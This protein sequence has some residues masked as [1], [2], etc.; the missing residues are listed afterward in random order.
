VIDVLVLYTADAMAAA[1]GK[2]A[3]EAKAQLAID[4]GNLAY[5]NSHIDATL[6]LVHVDPVTYTETAGATGFNDALNA[7]T[8]T[9]DG[10]I[11]EAHTLR[12]RYGADVVSLLVK[13]YSY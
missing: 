4:Q 13:N 12:D 2:D 11:N 9:T 1:G 8:S 5:A 10:L 6:N 7:V 3:I